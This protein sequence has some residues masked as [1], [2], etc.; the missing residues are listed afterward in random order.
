LKL[1]PAKAAID[2]VFVDRFN[3]EPTEN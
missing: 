1:E 2:M 3:K